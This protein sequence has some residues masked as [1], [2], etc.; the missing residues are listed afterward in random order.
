MSAARV[1]ITNDDGIDA[2]GL[3]AL[4]RA[5]LAHGFEAVV[6]APRSESSGSSAAMTAVVRRQRVVVEQ[7]QLPG[8][9]GATECYSVAGSPGYIVILA[10]LGVFGPPPDLVLSGINRGANA[11]QA[12]LHS[13]TV[14]AAFTAA[15][16]GRRAM[17]VSLD[18]LSPVE[19]A[20]ASDGTAMAVMDATDDAL[21]NWDTAGAQA[22]ALFPVLQEVPTGVVLNVN[23]PDVPPERLRGVTRTGLAHFGQV[24]MAIAEVGEGFVRTAVEDA[25]SRREPGTDLAALSEGFATV[26][27]LR[28]VVEADDVPFP[29]MVSD[30]RH[31]RTGTG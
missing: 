10:T 7:R 22:A 9:D 16:T 3:H 13:G 21:R 31:D 4:T 29:E 23:V 11:G 6:V 17:A 14:G 12:I 19:A 20:G 15:N 5:A 8:V 2:P 28:A 18:V 30:L 24:Q 1:L 25:G 27:A 26:T